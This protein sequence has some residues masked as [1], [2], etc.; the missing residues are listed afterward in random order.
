[1]L[2]AR[3]LG[4]EGRGELAAVILWPTLLA[5]L[6]DLGMAEASTFFAAR[7]YELRSLVGTGLAFALA[8]SLVLI[9]IGLLLLPLVLEQQREF[10]L[11]TAQLYLLF[12]PVNIIMLNLLGILNGLH[13][14]T[15]FHALRF[16]A[17]GLMMLALVA[18][19]GLGDLTVRSAALTYLIANCIIMVTAAAVVQ[20]ESGSAPK[21]DLGV[22]RSLI[23]FGLKTQTS[24]APALLNERLDQ[25]L[26]SVVLPPAT[27]GLYVIAVTLTSGTV[28]IGMAVS[29]V[30][31]PMISAAA[32][33]TAAR[34]RIRT[35]V[36]LTFVLSFLASA[37][38]AVEYP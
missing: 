7:G 34:E 2:L 38:I 10:V 5:F 13:R 28:L 6:G 4:P 11:D 25:L 18:L 1:M 3:T 9:T 29:L 31:L 32:S 35:F 27:L 30:A 37:L 16:S 36:S 20:R 12:I 14:F 19:A 26:V 33:T 8:Q 21:I 17:Y 15:W 23:G 24:A 22:G